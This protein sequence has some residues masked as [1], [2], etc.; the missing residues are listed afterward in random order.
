VAPLDP[1]SADRS[2]GH[3]GPDGDVSVE[4]LEQILTRLHGKSDEP[5]ATGSGGSSE[6]RP[7]TPEAPGAGTPLLPVRN[8]KP[9]RQDEPGR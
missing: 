6:R 2:H 4:L 8:R 3:D 5:A 7:V 9:R 1:T